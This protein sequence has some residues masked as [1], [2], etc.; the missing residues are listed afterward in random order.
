MQRERLGAFIFP[1]T[2][3]HNSE[4][5]ADHW[6]CREWISGFNGSAGTAVVTMTSAALW[7]DSRY[8]IAAAE[9]LKGTEFQLMKDGVAGTPTIAQWLGQQLQTTTNSTQRADSTEVAIDGSVVSAAAAERLVA[10]LRREGGLTLRTNLDAMRQIW[11]GR[12][13]IPTN[14]VELQPL[15]TIMKEIAERDYQDMHREVSPLRKADDAIEI[16]SSN[17]TIEEEVDQILKLAES[18]MEG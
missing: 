14:P 7:T 5:V 10:D 8:F 16:D 4:Y 9:Q 18:R 3:P 2:D 12:P 11:T 17:M 6:K 15:E 13:A 1:S